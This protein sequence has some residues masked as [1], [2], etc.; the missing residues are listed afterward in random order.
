MAGLL[1]YVWGGLLFAGGLGLGV[2]NGVIAQVS[3]VR[4]VGVEGLDRAMIVGSSL[5]RLGGITVVG[6]A[7]AWLARPTGWLLLVGLATYQ[8]LSLGLTVG[9]T[10]RELRSG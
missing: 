10:M 1:G 2:A 3:A 8:L 5:R 9:A 7:I 4:M 6:L